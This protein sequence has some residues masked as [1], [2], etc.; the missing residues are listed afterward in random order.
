MISNMPEP[1]TVT[2]DPIAPNYN[3]LRAIADYVEWEASDFGDYGFRALMEA[4]RL[5]RSVISQ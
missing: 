2:P 3:N 5:I 4:A 1:F